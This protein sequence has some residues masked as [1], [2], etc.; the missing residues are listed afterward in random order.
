VG[1]P[2]S[3]T[4]E[5]VHAAKGLNQVVRNNVQQTTTS[6][7][8]A[9]F[10]QLLIDI[11]PRLFA[12]I[13]TLLGDVHDASNVLQETNMTL[14]QKSD[15]FKPGTNFRAWAREIAYYKSL[16]FARDS[17]RDK[18]IVSQALIEQYFAESDD[19]DD[20]ER[21]IA[22]RHCVSKL[23]GSQR[24]LLRRRYEGNASMKQLSK[25]MGKSEAAVKMTLK[26]VRETLMTCI[27]RKL[28]VSP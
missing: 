5:K 28:L 17:K 22:L 25:Q 4:V 21:R 6:E 23:N 13:S 20:E 8:R 2:N 16:A 7:T 10:V 19:W 3:S 14:W 27:Q 18:L 24:Q 9:Q 1:I 15:D 12:Y 26:R 11:Q